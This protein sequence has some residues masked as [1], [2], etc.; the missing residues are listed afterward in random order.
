VLAVRAGPPLVPVLF[1]FFR[2]AC[3]GNTKMFPRASLFQLR[4]A[5]GSSPNERRTAR[6]QTHPIDAE[7]EL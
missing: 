1:L 6:S 3:H 4:K 2:P 5:T 7:L